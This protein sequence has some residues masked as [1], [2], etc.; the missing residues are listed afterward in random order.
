MT[1]KI[2]VPDKNDSVSRV[3]LAGQEYMIR[4]TW[5]ETCKSW[6]FGLYDM[7][8]MTLVNS[9]KIVPYSPMNYFYRT[10]GLPAGTFGCTSAKKAVG[11]RDFLTGDAEFIFIPDAD[12][13]GWDAE[14]AY[15]G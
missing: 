15:N 14:E 7:N 11:R 10:R 5:N 8:M 13:E 6:N 12:L 4:F 1:T 9:I 3:T 2:Q